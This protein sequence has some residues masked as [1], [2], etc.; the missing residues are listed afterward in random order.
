MKKLLALIVVLSTAAAFAQTPPQDDGAEP[1]PAPKAK[2]HKSA[3]VASNRS[4]A[5]KLQDCLTLD[6]GT[7]DRLDCYDGVIPPK[8]KPNPPAAKGVMDCKFVKEQDERLTCFNGFA[9]SIPKFGRDK[10]G[11]K[12]GIKPGK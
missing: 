4:I 3:A 2:P 12:A 1:A 11:S 7:K 6:D 10:P 9:E 5:E 8:P